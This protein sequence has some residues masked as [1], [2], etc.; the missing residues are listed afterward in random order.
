MPAAD[1]KRV[2]DEIENVIGL[3]AS[4]AVMASAKQGIGI[5]ELL[6]QIVEKVPA[7]DGNLDAPLQALIFD[8]KYD[9]YRGWY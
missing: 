5:E 2:Q 1:P 9:D 4:D 8:S 3:D 6:E 7:P